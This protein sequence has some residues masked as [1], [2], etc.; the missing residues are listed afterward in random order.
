MKKDHLVTSGKRKAKSNIHSEAKLSKLKIEG[1]F[2]NL[3]KSIYRKP[4]ADVILGKNVDAFPLRPRTRQRSPLL[5]LLVALFFTV[6]E[7]LGNAVRQ[8]KII[9]DK[10]DWEGRNKVFV[11]R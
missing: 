6:L 7:V 8:E 4:T 9:K 3:R 2:L 10:K 1:S 5:L 11:C